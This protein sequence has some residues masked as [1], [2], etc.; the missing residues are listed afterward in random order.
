[1]PILSRLFSVSPRVQR[2]GGRLEASA[3]WRAQLLTLGFGHRRV[4]VDPGSQTVVIESRKFWF[5]R[6][7]RRIP[8]QAICAIIYAYYDASFSMPWDWAYDTSD[9]FVVAL[10]LRDE[11]EVVLFRFVGSGEFRN[12]G[13]FPDWFYCEGM[14][15]EVGTQ[16]NESRAFVEV[17]S[18]MIGVPI[19]SRS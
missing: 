8:F 19:E 2:R 15:D 3:S 18:K 13:P 12:E 5:L 16:E 9:V 11:T 4:I 10:R 6:R 17:L 1:M 7:R 14:L